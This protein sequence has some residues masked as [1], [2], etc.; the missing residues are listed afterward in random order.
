[1]FSI[2]Q[3]IYAAVDKGAQIINISLGGYATSP[4]LT[5]AVD[6]ALA[7]NV[8]IV[9]AAGNDQAAQLTWPAAY[10]GVV[11]VGAVD[12]VGKQAIFSNSGPQLQLTAPGY[13]IA[14][15]GAGGSRV[16][17]SGTS[18]SAPVASGAIAALLSTTPGLN[19]LQAADLL[20]VYSDDHGPSGTD[21][22]YGRGTLNLDRALRREPAPQ[23]AKP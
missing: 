14:T 3:G 20:A 7:A 13:A 22:D 11:S 19:A 2:S 18:A 12:A 1:V 4:L 5:D 8:A 23:T 17:F 15:A 21:P 6:Y 9:A 16:S 10:S